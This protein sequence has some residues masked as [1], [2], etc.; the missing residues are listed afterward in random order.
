[1]Y[2]TPESFGMSTLSSC[3]DGDALYLRMTNKETES[4]GLRK[5]G[6]RPTMQASNGR[7][8]QIPGSLMR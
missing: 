6:E 8:G 3:C 7:V 4:C 5:I 2:M 1:M